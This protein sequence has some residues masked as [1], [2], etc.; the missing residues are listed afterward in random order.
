MKN[1]IGTKERE[2]MIREIFHDI[3]NG[4]S[5]SKIMDKLKSNGYN[6]Y[7]T[8]SM[9]QASYDRL[10]RDAMAIVKDNTQMDL[11]AAR[12]EMYNRLL[13]LYETCLE[14]GD[15]K[16]ALAALKQLSD[17]QGLDPSKKVDVTTTNSIKVNVSFGASTNDEEEEIVDGGDEE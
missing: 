10:Y 1:K 6:S 4:V 15:R 17:L 9:A 12:E 5:K 3:V 7:D 2:V 11:Q 16:N 8:D 13:S 14:Q